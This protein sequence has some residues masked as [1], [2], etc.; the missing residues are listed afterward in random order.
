M[1][2]AAFLL[3]Q[4]GTQTVDRRQD[5]TSKVTLR[6]SDRSLFADETLDAQ[7]RLDTVVYYGDS[8]SAYYIVTSTYEAPGV[9][10]RVPPSTRAVRRSAFCGS[11]GYV[12]SGYS[13]SSGTLHWVFVSGSAPGNLDL[14]L[15]RDEHAQRAHRV[16]K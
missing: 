15:T 3:P 11:T 16:G 2:G 8:G 12:E 6:R 4:S 5:E 7:G 10:T 1:A 9:P 14:N 13:W